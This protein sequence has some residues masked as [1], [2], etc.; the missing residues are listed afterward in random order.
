MPRRD[1]PRPSHFGGTRSPGYTLV[2]KDTPHNP[3]DSASR[4]SRPPGPVVCSLVCSGGQ[5]VLKQESTFPRL[6]PQV[7]A[8]AM[9]TPP[10]QETGP[11]TGVAVEGGWGGRSEAA[12]PRDGK[13]GAHAGRAGLGSPPGPLAAC[14]HAD[15]LPLSNAKQKLGACDSHFFPFKTPTPVFFQDSTQH[16]PRKELTDLNFRVTSCSAGTGEA[17]S[18]SC[19]A[20]VSLDPVRGSQGAAIRRA[21][22]PGAR[23]GCKQ[24]KRPPSDHGRA[25]RQ[26]RDA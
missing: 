4:G 9:R 3:R 23:D 19:A 8:G 2:L 20:E 18:N 12:G 25:E 16:R 11:G 14:P 1:L 13:S 5:E 15:L 26:E 17:S 22:R 21:T 10:A 7:D 24:S 6:Q